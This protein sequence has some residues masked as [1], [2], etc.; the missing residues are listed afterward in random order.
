MPIVSGNFSKALWPGI[1]KWYGDSYAEREQEWTKL[2]DVFDSRKA[3]EED[4][5]VSGFGLASVKGEG[6]A[7]TFD[8]ARQGFINRYTHA[9]YGLGFIITR[10][11][12]ED[13]LYDVIGKK[14]ASS[15]AWSMRQTKETVVANLYNRAFSTTYTFG[16]GKPILSASHP[17]IAGG[18]W[19]NLIGTAADVSEAA[20]EQA[21]IDIAK[22]TN[23]R[24]LKIAVK[25]KQII[26]PVD[27]DFE[28]NKILQTQ[29]EVGT[30]NNT[31]NV[32][33]SRF[34][35]G[36]TVNHYLTDTDAW[37][38]RT[39]APDGLKL[40]QRRAD[41]F[42]MD[43][44]WDTENARYKATMRFSVGCSDGRQLYGSAGA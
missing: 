2:V 7:I 35:G 37:F 14:K 21:Y 25:P 22:F 39:D 40:F 42:D 29:Y 6:A 31:V 44:D 19:S 12:V 24:G 30:T 23:D 41:S 33:R 32:V 27:V 18:T 15:L 26:V 28:V 36:A 16:D 38:I 43:N 20:L 1:N 13:D 3:T 10:E 8:T 17:N 5:S 9:V 11:M 4:V 34:P